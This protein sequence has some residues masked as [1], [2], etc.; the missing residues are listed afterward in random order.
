MSIQE[1]KIEKFKRLAI[2]RGNRIL[3]D[4]GLLGN[5]ANRNNY[6]YSQED[7]KK[8]F[9]AIDEQIKET[10]SQFQNGISKHQRKIEL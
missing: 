7:V 8:L 4:I 9:S 3:R 10:K 1:T 2:V 5:L 6:E